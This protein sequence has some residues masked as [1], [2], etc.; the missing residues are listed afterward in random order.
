MPSGV[1]REGTGGGSHEPE[2][3]RRRE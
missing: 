3:A 1:N 2:R